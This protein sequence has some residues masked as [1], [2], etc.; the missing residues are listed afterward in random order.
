MSRMQRPKPGALRE[1]FGNEGGVGQRRYR[2]LPN[3]PAPTANRS[4]LSSISVGCARFTTHPDNGPGET[5]GACC[6]RQLRRR[7]DLGVRAGDHPDDVGG[8]GVLGGVDGA[9]R[10]RRAD[11]GPRQ[12]FGSTR[13][14]GHR[15]S[16]GL[17]VQRSAIS[18]S[19]GARLSG[20][21]EA[22]PCGIR[23]RPNPLGRRTASAVGEAE[24]QVGGDGVG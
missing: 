21:H 11:L 17:T 23:I 13:A 5:S 18:A 14:G 19:V 8:S 7:E 20:V 16:G 1:G 2:R 3:L 22:G 12:A 10:A 4:G 15:A 24:P 6:D 9:W